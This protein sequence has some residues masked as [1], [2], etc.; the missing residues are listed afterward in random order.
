MMP[1]QVYKESSAKYECTFIPTTYG[2]GNE[3]TRYILK[4]ILNAAHVTEDSNFEDLDFFIF[5]KLNGFMEMMG[6][7]RPGMMPLHQFRINIYDEP[8]FPGQKGHMRIVIDFGHSKNS[9]FEFS[10]SRRNTVKKL[11]DLALRAVSRNVSHI[12]ERIN[13]MEIPDIPDTFKMLLMLDRHN[14]WINWAREK[15][16]EKTF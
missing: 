8:F 14:Y 5:D 1:R 3:R 16:P 7:W 10:L 15:F 6:I 13:K 11:K 12:R 9:I 4:I 2:P